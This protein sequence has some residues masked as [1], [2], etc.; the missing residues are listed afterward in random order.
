MSIEALCASPVFLS[1]NSD[2]KGTTESVDGTAVF[3]TVSMGENPSNGHNSAYLHPC[4][5]ANWIARLQN[6]AS[7]TSDD[8]KYLETF[9]ML[10][11]AVVEMRPGSKGGLGQPNKISLLKSGNNSKDGVDLEITTTPFADLIKRLPNVKVCFLFPRSISQLL[12]LL[13]SLCSR[14]KRKSIEQ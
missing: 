2:K 1:K 14:K 7:T 3:P 8:F 6:E 10:C 9:I 5:T 13:F 4:E 12:T 11:S